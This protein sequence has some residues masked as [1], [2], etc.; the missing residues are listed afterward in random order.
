MMPRPGLID[1]I[2]ATVGG[3][4]LTGASWSAI[5]GGPDWLTATAGVSGLLT[6]GLALAG[7]ANDLLHRI[8]RHRAL[9]TQE[10]HLLGCVDTTAARLQTSGLTDSERAQLL[11]E[12]EIYNRM[13]DNL[14]RR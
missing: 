7:R 11:S 4:G 1:A 9:R 14:R 3:A 12:F 6:S 5:A 2:T 10:G 8:R 13:L